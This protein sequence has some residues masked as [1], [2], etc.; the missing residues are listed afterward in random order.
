MDQYVVAGAV[1]VALVGGCGFFIY[2]MRNRKFRKK[3]MAEAE[4]VPGRID[5]AAKDVKSEF[6]K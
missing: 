6:R 3:V 1:F 5:R 4:R 2:K